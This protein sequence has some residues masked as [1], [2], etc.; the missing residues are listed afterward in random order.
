MFSFLLGIYLGVELLLS[1]C[2]ILY[3][4][5]QCV[6]FPIFPCPRQKFLLSDFLIVAILV[7]VKWYLIIVL[8]CII[9]IIH[10][11]EQLFM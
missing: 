3:S 8:I 11:I 2:I 7:G 10:N 6:S 1:G 9:I 4:L 5:W